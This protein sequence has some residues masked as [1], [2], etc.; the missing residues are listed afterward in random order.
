MKEIEEMY[1]IE[2]DKI[3]QFSVHDT[4]RQCERAKMNDEIASKCAKITE[5][6]AIDFLEYYERTAHLCIDSTG[7]NFGKP[8]HEVYQEF[9]KNKRQ[10]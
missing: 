9:L 7:E 4:N 8:Y 6:I 1:L 10:S 2:I 5:Q 3:N